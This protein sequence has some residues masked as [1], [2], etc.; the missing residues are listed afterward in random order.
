MIKVLFTLDYEIHGNGQGDPVELMVAPTNR[1]LE[2]FDTYGAKLTIMADMAE[3]IKFKE[4]LEQSGKDKFGYLK[5]VGQLQQAVIKGHDVQLHIHSSYFNAE[6]ENDK[7]KNCWDDYDLASLPYDR[8]NNMIR[9]SKELLESIIKKVDKDYSCNVF[10]AANW[11]MIPSKNIVQALKNNCIKV[12]TSVFKYGRRRGLVNFDYSECHSN[13]I[14]WPADEN[15]INIKSASGDIIEFPIFSES[16]PVWSFFS[17]N[18]MHR[19]Y[20]SRRHNFKEGIEHHLNKGNGNFAKKSLVEKMYSKLM[21]K[22]ALK[23]DFNQCTGYQLIKQLKRVEKEYV[24]AKIDVPFITIGHSKLFTTLNKISLKPFLK[25][26]S[27]NSNK[28]KFA[29]FK[30]FDLKQYLDLE[31]K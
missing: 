11:S 5:I 22:N 26:V 15:D 24:H 31:T 9:D 6:Y 19:A 4:Y 20:L 23:A 13:A 16:A 12:D 27:E 21:T 8:L 30:D 25:F 28:Y 7:W 1:M 17:L 3:I 10:R 29:I 18:R 2:L 14:P